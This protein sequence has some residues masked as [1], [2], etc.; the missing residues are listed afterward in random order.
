[1]QETGGEVQRLLQSVSRRLWSTWACRQQPNGGA[2]GD[3]EGCDLDL[4]SSDTTS[5]SGGLLRVGR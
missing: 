3:G 4:Q 5:A 2:S 1:M